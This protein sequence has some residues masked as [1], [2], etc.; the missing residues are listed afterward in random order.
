MPAECRSYWVVMAIRGPVDEHLE[1][2]A[3][4]LIR[5]RGRRLSQLAQPDQE[6]FRQEVAKLFK[7][8][9][10]MVSHATADTKLL[11]TVFNDFLDTFRSKVERLSWSR[12]TKW[13]LAMTSRGLTLSGRLYVE[14]R[15]RIHAL[16]ADPSEG[17]AQ[18]PTLEID[19]DLTSVR[20]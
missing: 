11:A 14:L 17:R 1:S 19:P 2:I 7:V 8:A 5:H 10:R 18:G 4:L 20:F 3:D 6:M 15:R 16:Q 13:F 12:S 9:A